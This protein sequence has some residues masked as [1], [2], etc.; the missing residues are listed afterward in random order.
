MSRANQIRFMR[1]PARLPATGRNNPN[2]LDADIALAVA[3]D[4]CDAA[5]QVTT[6]QMLRP[7]D[8][9]VY[10]WQVRAVQTE[11]HNSFVPSRLE[12]NGD[13]LPVRRNARSPVEAR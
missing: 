2:G 12:K 6:Q 5:R 13:P 7:L 10:Q 3:A 4:K 9:D 8:Q 11:I 1:K